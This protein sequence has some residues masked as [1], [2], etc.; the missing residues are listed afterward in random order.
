MPRGSGS[1]GRP[2]PPPS[3]RRRLRRGPDGSASP[4]G[5]SGKSSSANA[6][7]LEAE[8][9]LVGHDEIATADADCE[10]GLVGAVVVASARGHQTEPFGPLGQVPSKLGGVVG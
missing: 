4:E 7:L 9:R 6:P 10:A 8:D 1:R 2:S 5:S 3:C